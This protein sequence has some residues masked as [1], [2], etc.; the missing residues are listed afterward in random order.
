MIERELVDAITAP[1]FAE[2]G[3]DGQRSEQDY[4]HEALWHIAESSAA[5]RANIKT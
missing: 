1:A 5:P 3:R 4:A 2:T